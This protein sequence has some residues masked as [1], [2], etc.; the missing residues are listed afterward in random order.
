MYRG[1]QA[2]VQLL[3]DLINI[4]SKEWL[5]SMKPSVGGYDFI[6]RSRHPPEKER[7]WFPLACV[8]LIFCQL[9]DLV[10]IMRVGLFLD[11]YWFCKLLRP[12]G[13]SKPA[14]TRITT[15]WVT[16]QISLMQIYRLSSWVRLAINA[17]LLLCG[18]LFPTI[19]ESRKNLLRTEQD[20]LTGSK[21]H[22]TVDCGHARSESNQWSRYVNDMLPK[23]GRNGEACEVSI[24]SAAVQYHQL[25]LYVESRRTRWMSIFFLWCQ[26]F[27]SLSI[28]SNVIDWS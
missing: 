25:T 17:F 22:L 19:S 23:M 26:L 11:R 3:K 9:F 14:R 10:D 6:H 1:S 12:E 24:T 27:C 4:T 20:T 7:C 13:A 28:A 16:R 21:C 2:N 8:R 18:C 5:K 15:E